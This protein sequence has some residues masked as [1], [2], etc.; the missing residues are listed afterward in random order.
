M[1]FRITIFCVSVLL[2]SCA[3]KTEKMNASKTTSVKHHEKTKAVD[4]KSESQ[5]PEA[6]ELSG[7]IWVAKPDGSKSCGTQSGM[8]TEQASAELKKAGIKVF[9]LKNGQDGLMHMMVCGAATG[10]TLDALIDGSQYSAAQKL[11]YKLKIK[12]P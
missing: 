10:T 1:F 4:S 11:G 5:E 8:T 12:N 2:F 9:Q 6:G 7:H 3:G